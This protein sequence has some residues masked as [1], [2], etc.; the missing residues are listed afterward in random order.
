MTAAT[1]KPARTAEG[2][3][4]MH[5]DEKLDF[6]AVLLAA[7]TVPGKMSNAYSRF[8]HYSF[9]NMVLVYMQ[10]GKL[11]P[12][13]T[14]KKWVALGRNVVRGQKALF[15]N[16]PRPVYKRDEAGN[17]V[18]KDGKPVIAFT[19]FIPKATVFQLFQTDG[20][21]L[22][23]PETPEWN[24]DEALKVLDIE[25]VKF[26]HSDGN[27]QGYS[28]NRTFALNPVAV[29]PFKTM[30][31][32][33][34]HIVLGHTDKES[35]AEYQT[36]RGIKEFQA[37]A[38]ALLVSRELEVEGFDESASRAYIQNWLGIDR[39]SV[40]DQLTWNDEIEDVDLVNDQVVRE[41][42]SVT[43]KI[44][45]AGRKRHFEKLAEQAA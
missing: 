21:E 29:S 14:F 25:E 43:E 41:I 9:L 35:L 45:I 2:V 28:V 10:T 3:L 8:Y 13:A 37:E 31:H 34:A 18:L 16:H 33:L 23:M 27:T 20:P 12:V 32:E 19:M 26:S 1:R 7:L 44:L 24:K 36:H 39:G 11:E 17:T 15:V 40:P 22:Q 5:G 4:P 6:K 42:F 30:I 38:V